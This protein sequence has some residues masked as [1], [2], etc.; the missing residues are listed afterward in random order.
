L[1]CWNSVEH[2]TLDYSDVD[3]W[4][5]PRQ[6]PTTPG[7]Y[8]R[9]VAA[10]VLAGP[11]PDGPSMTPNNP[12]GSRQSKRVELVAPRQGQRH[13]PQPQLLSRTKE[14]CE[15]NFST[16]W[17]LRSPGEGLVIDRSTM[18]LTLVCWCACRSWRA[19]R[20]PVPFLPGSFVHSFVV[21]STNTY[22]ACVRA[23]GAAVARLTM[24]TSCRTTAL[25]CLGCRV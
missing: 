2:R 1:C 24:T 10:A 9:H 19:V 8:L 25:S 15:T 17:M 14:D 23:M 21:G 12:N 18:T 3:T 4:L 11:N 20:G 13:G 5:R 7:Q 22:G 6:N 16:W